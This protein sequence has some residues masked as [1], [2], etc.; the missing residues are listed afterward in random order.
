MCSCNGTGRLLEDSGIG[1]VIFIPC[2][3]EVTQNSK[4]RSLMR[5]AE[6]ETKLIAAEQ[7]LER[8]IN[9]A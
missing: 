6:F 9:H 2:S 7:E 3:C 1:G 4:E 5:M 8:C